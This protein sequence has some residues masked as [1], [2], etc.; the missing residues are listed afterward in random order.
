[1][2]TLTQPGT[3]FA[4]PFEIETPPGAEGW[5]WDGMHLPEV[6]LPFETHTHEGWIYACSVVNSRIFAVPPSFGFTQR[7]LNGYEYVALSPVTDPKE[8]AKRSGRDPFR[9]GS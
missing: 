9:H 7:M 2:A 6:Q 8:R 3:R 1:M 5:M 4:S